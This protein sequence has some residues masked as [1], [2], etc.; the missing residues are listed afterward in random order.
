M[1]F[2]IW[3]VCLNKGHVA[4]FPRAMVEEE[5]G[6]FVEITEPK[7]LKLAD[8]LADVWLDDAPEI[9]GFTVTRPPANPH[10]PFWPALL[11]IMRK[12]QTVLHWPTVGPKPHAVVADGSVIAHMPPDMVRILGTPNVVT[13]PEEFWQRIAESGA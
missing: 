8:S 11:D 5:F 1:S 3:L 12:T 6:P 4:T 13:K 9:E 2:E 7:R 10:H